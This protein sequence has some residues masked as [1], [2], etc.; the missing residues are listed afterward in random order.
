LKLLDHPNNLRAQ[1]LP[2]NPEFKPTE[3]QLL[4]LL[5]AADSEYG[6]IDSSITWRVFMVTDHDVGHQARTGG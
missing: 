3:K 5:K 1:R 6:P 4:S 2:Q